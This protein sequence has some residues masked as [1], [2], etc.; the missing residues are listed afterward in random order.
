MS[1]SAAGLP[2]CELYIDGRWRTSDDH[3]AVIDPTTEDTVGQV[4]EARVRDAE[5][6]CAAARAAQEPWARLDPQQRGRYL[7]AVAD[8]LDKDGD[9]LIELSMTESGFPRPV[10]AAHLAR[11]IDWFRF[12][13][14]ATAQDHT[15]STVP[16]IVPAGPGQSELLN[17]VIQRRPVGVVACIVPFNGPLFGSAMKVAQALAM[18]NSAIV[19]PAP[20][21][22][23]AVGEFFKI[24]ERVGLPA[25]VANLVTSGD[26]S[27]GA[28]ITSSKDVDMVSFTGSTTVG[29]HVYRAG[30]ATMKRLLLELGGKGACLVCEDADL[31]T[32]ANGIA[33]V[34]RVN[35][36]QSCSAPTRVI[37]NRRVHDELVQ[38]LVDIAKTIKVGSPFD[39]ETTMGPVVCE[40]QRDRIE[41]FI[42]SAREEGADV[43]VGGDR[44]GHDRGFFVAPTLLTSCNNNMLAVRNEIFGP[45][46]SVIAC[47]DDEQAVEIANDS[48]YGLYSYVFSGNRLRAL[49]L[50]DRLVA[51]TVQVNTV[52]MKDD[53]PRGGVKMSGLGRECGL[54]GL[55][56]YSEMCSVVWS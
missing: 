38:R 21:N 13:A 3:R 18:G 14:S 42:A 2:T 34:W 9:H 37:V 27:V 46:V 8:E 35:S 44:A 25:G 49:G 11:A 20:Q 43:A 54:I 1:S 36:G 16:A 15:Q 17:G 28:A 30:A 4:A 29:E 56:E 12:T 40:S 55:Y 31:D 53:M 33:N 24:L 23:L 45:V 52:R 47:D 50:S 32:A 10:A 26:P 22:P 7:D 39:P 6:A 5:D 41:G 19:K 48:D 51:G